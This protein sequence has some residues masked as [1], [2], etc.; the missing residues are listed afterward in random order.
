MC[1][2]VKTP[3]A[4][5]KDR[6][7]PD[8]C[9]STCKVCRRE[10]DLLRRYGLTRASYDALLTEQQGVCAICATTD[11]GRGHRFFSV[12]HDHSTGEVRGLLC[13][14]C[15]VGIGML[16]RDCRDSIPLL[17]ALVKYLRHPPAKE[18][19]Q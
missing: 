19:I 18:V 4:F 16:L 10:Y 7:S 15:N 11:P 17:L 3:D 1:R 12:D 9:A 13:N 2:A 14:N 6:R 8:G 5:Y